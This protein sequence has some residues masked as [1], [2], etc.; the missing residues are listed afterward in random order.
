MKVIASINRPGSE[1]TENITGEVKGET[2]SHYLI[3]RPSSRGGNA[4]VLEWFAKRSRRV[5]CVVV[6]D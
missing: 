5:S 1:G 6:E 4:E 2:N 3:H